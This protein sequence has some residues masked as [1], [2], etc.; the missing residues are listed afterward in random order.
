MGLMRS[1]E[2]NEE[3]AVI[4]KTGTPDLSQQ[5]G[6]RDEGVAE[7]GGEKK[8]ADQQERLAE[9]EDVDM[10]DAS[11]TAVDKS[12]QDTGNAEGNGADLP[13]GE[14]DDEEV[15]AQDV[16]LCNDTTLF[17]A[18]AVRC[19]RQTQLLKNCGSEVLYETVCQADAPPERGMLKLL[20]KL[21]FSV[22]PHVHAQGGVYSNGVD[23]Y[24]L[25]ITA[26]SLISTV[27]PSTA[28]A[29]S[30]VVERL[31]NQNRSEEVE[32]LEHVNRDVKRSSQKREGKG[33]YKLPL[34]F[35]LLNVILEEPVAV[36]MPALVRYIVDLLWCAIH[37][38]LI[39]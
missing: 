4:D 28:Q 16:P 33:Y 21:L 31:Q 24:D 2:E 34:C 19:L 23:I 39:Q 14:E 35:G 30:A 17:F 29:C 12:D 9:G 10:Q 6:E 22:I 13:P 26:R 32:L 18:L 7:K 8:N 3:A 20:A 11:T 38:D 27:D 5:G 37:C 15:T 36:T 1:A 25:A